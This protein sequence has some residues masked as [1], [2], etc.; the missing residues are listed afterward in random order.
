MLRVNQ[1]NH[2][3]N[4]ANPKKSFKIIGF[5]CLATCFLSQS[6]LG[7]CY[8]NG[9]GIPKDINTAIEWFAKAADQGHEDAKRNLKIV[10]AML[11]KN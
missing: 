3:S 6:Q 4:H 11:K 5:L 9:E 7:V 8:A 1:H 10:K 2:F